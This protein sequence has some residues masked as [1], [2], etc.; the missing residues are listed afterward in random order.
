MRYFLG[1]SLV[2]W[3]MLQ[4]SEA[5]AQALRFQPQGAAA[6]GQ[7]SEELQVLDALFKHLQ[8]HYDMHEEDGDHF[9]LKRDACAIT[10]D[11][12]PNGGRWFNLMAR[13]VLGAR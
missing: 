11:P 9:V 4:L 13:P 12:L 8:E 3:L 5:S 7:G 1:F 6:A 10:K 2:V